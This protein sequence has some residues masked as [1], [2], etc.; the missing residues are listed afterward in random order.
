MTRCR[1]RLYGKKVTHDDILE[2]IDYAMLNVVKRKSL[3]KEIKKS[4]KD[5]KLQVPRTFEGK[6]GKK[7]HYRITAW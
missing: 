1:L 2:E 5:F 4:L 3:Q 6:K 7:G